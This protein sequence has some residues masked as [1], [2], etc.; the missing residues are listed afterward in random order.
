M[1]DTTA[2]SDAVTSNRFGRSSFSGQL[3]GISNI[4][5]ID[6]FSRALPLVRFTR[7]AGT[8]EAPRV[9]ARSRAVY[10]MAFFLAD[11]IERQSQVIFAPATLVGSLRLGV[12]DGQRQE[13]TGQFTQGADDAVPGRFPTMYTIEED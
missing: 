8:A 12:Q 4:R 2:L 5:E 11:N 10:P 7:K 6:V 13:W 3:T 1:I 9:T